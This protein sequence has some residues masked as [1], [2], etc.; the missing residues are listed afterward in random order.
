MENGK[1]KMENGKWK[2]ENGSRAT[3]SFPVRGKFQA[4]FS[5]MRGSALVAGFFGVVVDGACG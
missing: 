3:L 5:K 1:W 4:E 2:M